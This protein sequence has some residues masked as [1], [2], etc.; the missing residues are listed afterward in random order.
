METDKQDRKSP[1]FELSRE[2]LDFVQ[3]MVLASGSLKD[4]AKS[5]GVTYP[6]IRVRLNKLIER[7][8]AI[9]ENRPIDPIVELIANL[10]DQG[11]VSPIAARALIDL[12]R[13]LK[14]PKG[15]S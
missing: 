9:V 8:Q 12:H 6:T 14:H 2:D 5:Y 10:V 1:L 15:G 11:E 4:L 7:L 3:R 13:Q